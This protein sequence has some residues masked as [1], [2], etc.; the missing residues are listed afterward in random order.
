MVWGAFCEL[1]PYAIIIFVVVI[2][3]VDIVIVV[4]VVIIIVRGNMAP[5]MVASFNTIMEAYVVWFYGVYT[6]DHLKY[7][8]VVCSGFIVIS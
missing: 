7:A 3:Y 8:L 6:D 1:K 2:V 4:V 5:S